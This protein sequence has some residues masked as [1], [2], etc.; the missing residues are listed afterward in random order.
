MNG[1]YW[2]KDKSEMVTISSDGV[3]MVFQ[4]SGIGQDYI[5]FKMKRKN[6]FFY[7]NITL[8]FYP[9]KNECH[10]KQERIRKVYKK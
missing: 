10:L 7:E 3:N 5:P 4:S 6:E 8:K 9:E 1:T 2:V